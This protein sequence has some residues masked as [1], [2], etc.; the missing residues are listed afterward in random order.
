MT[1]SPTVRKL[2]LTAHIASSVGLLGAIL[3]FLTLA[4]AGLTSTD[5]QMVR[6]AY[7]A[8]EL[9]AWFVIVPLAL[10]SLVIG[11]AQGLG[12]P[13][14]LFQHYWVAAKLV[15]TAFA[16]VILL[17]Q[18]RTISDMARI[19]NETTLSGNLRQ[20][21]ISLAV[22]AAGGMLTLLGPLALSVYKPRGRIR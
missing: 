1:M 20:A 9:I 8:M 5:D 16:I 4:I 21:R 7:L 12:T 18:M 6:A 15:L 22:H 10:A 3:G 14:G 19:A 13:W 17:M 2:V 11:V